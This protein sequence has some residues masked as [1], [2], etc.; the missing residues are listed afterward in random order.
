MTRAFHE[1]MPNDEII[2]TFPKRY[3]S[4]DFSNFT[5][6]N[7]DYVLITFDNIEQLRR[8]FSTKDFRWASGHRLE[9]FED[10]KPNTVI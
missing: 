2:E 1:S 10:F 9:T 3:V 8:Y 5:I 7:G 4:F 6:Q